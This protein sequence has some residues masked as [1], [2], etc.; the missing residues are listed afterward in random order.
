MLT[1]GGTESQLSRLIRPILHLRASSCINKDLLCWFLCL[2]LG[3]SPVMPHAWS[4]IHSN[5]LWLLVGIPRDARTI[6]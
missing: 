2:I 3:L 5:H 1:S 6:S 4:S